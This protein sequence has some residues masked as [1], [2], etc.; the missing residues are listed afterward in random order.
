VARLKDI[1][2]GTKDL[3]MLDPAKITE[4]PGWNARVDG[5][6]L[7]THIRQLADSIKEIGVQEPVTVYM[8]GDT[9]VLTN[10]HCRLMAVR[11]AMSEGAEIKSIP[12]RVEERYSNDADRVLSLITRNSGKPLSPLEQASVVKRLIQFGW[13]TSQIAAKTGFSVTHVNDLLVLGGAPTQV[14][15]MVA[16]GEVSAANAVKTIRKHK[17]NAPEKLQ[18]ARTAAGSSRVTSK[19]LDK[20]TGINWQVIGPKLLA[21]VTKMREAVGDD[22]EY[23]CAYTDLMNFASTLEV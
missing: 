21:A 14:T 15:N 3:Y 16:N 4:E 18:E 8:K 20:P 11:L 9:V 5:P 10:G 17:E 22:L 12:C 13:V 23:G 1:A 2:E 19:H 7:D 6:D